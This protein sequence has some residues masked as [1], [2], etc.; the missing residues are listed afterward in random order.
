MKECIALQKKE[1]V[2]EDTDTVNPVLSDEEKLVTYFYLLDPKD[3]IQVLRQIKDEV[4]GKI[5]DIYLLEEE[6]LERENIEVPV[7]KI[8]KLKSKRN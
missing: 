5:S 8:N 7:E 2:I 6:D 3:Q 1:K 4:T